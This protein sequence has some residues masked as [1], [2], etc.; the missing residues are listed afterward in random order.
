MEF[1]GGVEDPREVVQLWLD[2]WETFPAGKLVVETAAGERIGRVGVNFYDP[3]RWIRSSSPDARPELTWALAYEHWGKGYATEAAAAFRD[4][5]GGVGLI[6][7]I[8][9]LNV[10]SQQV[11]KRLGATPGETIELPD[12][13]AHV[14]WE[15][16]G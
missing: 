2:G 16:P 15:H 14:V 7:L 12:A 4:W 13:G 10:R 5:F 11:A 3:V 1:L 8:A 6:S 9:P